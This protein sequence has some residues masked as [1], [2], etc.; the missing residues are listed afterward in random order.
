LRALRILDAIEWSARERRLAELSSELGLDK[1]TTLRILETLVAERVVRKDV[2][3][4]TYSSDL[5][6]WTY[7]TPF[8]RAPQALIS[9][10]QRVLDHLAESTLSTSLL[11]LPRV[12]ARTVSPAMYSL[13]DVNVYY[14]PAFAPMESPVQA[15]AAGKCYLAALPKEELDRHLES[16][17]EGAT[18]K[19]ITSRSRLRKELARVR[20]QGYALNLG[21]VVEASSAVAVPLHGPM[22]SV[23]GGAAIGFARDD[24][25]RDTGV[26]VLPLLRSGAQEIG[27]LMSYAPRQSGVEEAH[28][29]QTRPLSPWDTPDPGL[30][31]AGAV[32]VRTVARMIR[33]MALLFTRPEGASV[34]EVAE[35]RELGKST[36]WRLLNTLA[37]A[38][39]LWQDA[40]DER[41]RISPLFWLS[42][43]SVLRSA[44]SLS[45]A[46]EAILQEVAL[47]TGATAALGLPDRE[48]RYAVASQFALPN[49][50]LC[51]HVGREPSAPLH[52]AAAGKCYLAA[53]PKLVVKRYIQ[54][55]LSA[56]TD[57]TITSGE[58]LLSELEDVRRQGYALT[59]EEMARGVAALALPVTDATGAIVGGL[60]SIR[61]VAKFTDADV[62]QW[63]PVLRRAADRISS[64]LV[65]GWR[66]ELGHPSSG[67]PAT[68]RGKRTI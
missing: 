39:L 36:A 17:L 6:S 10:V 18:D 30:E 32:R 55:G 4:G 51:W 38:G 50:P 41:Y 44:A 24:E 2:D 46:V 22:G 11:V 23:V 68:R 54:G 40:P 5:T 63:V 48:G 14:D 49:N 13:P 58:Q 31:E 62:R 60:T 1:A 53:Q 19:T 64:L 15:A 33:L 37:S 25:A 61:V 59:R 20:R 67:V 35:Q 52:T 29:S 3:S 9:G 16:E 28:T 12:G 7:L 66:E 34:A 65:A 47:A 26:A 42:R 27:D 8:L 57:V 21:E 56:L 45:Q 43:A